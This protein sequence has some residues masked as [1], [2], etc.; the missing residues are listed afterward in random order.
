MYPKSNRKLVTLDT[1]HEEVTG[2]LTDVNR[3]SVHPEAKR[4]TVLQ[5]AAPTPR[6]RKNRE[7]NVGDREEGGCVNHIYKRVFTHRI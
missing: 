2:P 7:D 6:R 4:A 1:K 3:R 5:R